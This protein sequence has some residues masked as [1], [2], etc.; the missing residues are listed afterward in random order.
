MEKK[1]FILDGSAYC[2]RAYYAVHNL[3]TSYGKPTGAIYGFINMLNKL[4]KEEKPEYLAVCFDVKGPTIR[5]EKFKQYKINRKPTPPELIE[6]IDAIKELVH[7]YNINIF[8]KAKYEADDLIASMVNRLKDKNVDI[9]VISGDK[10]MLQL[11]DRNVVIYNPHHQQRT[12]CNLEWVKERF[13]ITPRQFV[14]IIALMGDSADNI[15]G[16]PGIGEKTAVELISRFNTLENLLLHLNDVSGDK[17]RELLREYAPQ[18]KLSKELAVICQDIPLDISLD[19]LK[20]KLPDYNR[21]FELYRMWEFNSL[22]DALPVIPYAAGPQINEMENKKD[23]VNKPEEIEPLIAKLSRQKKFS[24]DIKTYTAELLPQAEYCFDFHSEQ[25][26]VFSIEISNEKSKNLSMLKVLFEN[27]DQ[28]KI[29]YDAKTMCIIL[30]GLNIKLCPPLFDVLL[31]AYLLNPERRGFSLPELG[32]EFIKGNF[33]DRP[34]V[35]I[36]FKLM[37]MFEQTLEEQ[38]MRKVFVEL[39][40]PLSLILAGMELRGIAVNR[41]YLKVLSLELEQKIAALTQD[42][43]E[44][45]GRRFNINSPKQLSEVLFID[46]KLPVVKRTKT[47]FSTDEAVLRKLLTLHSLPKMLLEYRE[48]TKLK[49]TYVDS[50]IN[51]I[52]KQSG[53]IHASFNQTVTATGR[54]SSSNPNLQNVPIRTQMGREIRKVFIASKADW[55]LISSDYSQIE[56]RILAHLSSDRNL[57]DIFRHGG[58]VHRHT[59]SLIFKTEE[60]A[61][62]YQMRDTAKRINFGIIYGMGPYGLSKDLNISIDEATNFIDEYFLRYP[63]VKQFIEKIKEQAE[64]NGFVTTIFN[65][66]RYIPQI[67]SL[68]NNIRGF[69]ERIAIN[70]PIQGTAADIIKM[71]M[72]KINQ[73]LSAITRETGM[74]IQVHDELVFEVKDEHLDR[75]V[76]IIKNEMEHVVILNVPLSVSVKVGKN[77]L[78]M[79]E[80]K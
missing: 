28:M 1:L 36:M 56:L 7:V 71:A 66:R 77:W 23:P 35:L 9:Y 68:N 14:D 10:D 64:V 41:D 67:N 32:R 4:I 13:K 24:F 21:L 61:V 37:K 27:S 78:E 8:E 62:T 34:G 31:A 30:A 25:T 38:K 55:S 70:S 73:A 59:A 44:A 6:Q 39:E 3:S 16:V 54:L 65:R 52:N 53:R 80:Y 46:L 5:H 11:V 51:L 42:I 29:C 72:V 43:F 47:S 60:S 50:L 57:I 12:I 74:L 2:Y 15:P 58:D 26:G 33:F 45:A 19:K 76:E 20:F 69:A 48:L 18:A 40:I 75:V 63:E 49:S 17:R 22:I 79:R